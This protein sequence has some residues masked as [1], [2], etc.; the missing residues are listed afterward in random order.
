MILFN[1]VYLQSSTKLDSHYLNSFNLELNITNQQ[2]KHSSVV[3]LFSLFETNY[4]YVENVIQE[5][6]KQQDYSKT[7]FI[8]Y[9]AG[10]QIV[11]Y[12]N[13]KF[14]AQQRKLV[15]QQKINI[16][17][18][19]VNF[20]GFD[21]IQI[22]N[23]FIVKVDQNATDQEIMNTLLELSDAEYFCNW[24]STAFH[25]SSRVSLQMK[26][27]E[28]NNANVSVLKQV[29]TY[30][31]LD[32]SITMNE[33]LE[34]QLE[35]ILFKRECL[36]NINKYSSF[37]DLTLQIAQ[38]NTVSQVNAVT[39]YLDLS[40][41]YQK[42][43]MILDDSSAKY[44]LNLARP[45]QRFDAVISLGAWCQVNSM[46]DMRGLQIV[47]S[48]FAGFAFFKWD[49]LVDVLE[50][51]FSHYWEEKNVHLGRASNWYSY[52]YKD[53]RLVRHAYDSRYNMFSPHHFDLCD[54]SP[55]NS[56]LLYKEFSQKL[57]HKIQ[58]FNL[59]A[60]QSR[61]V[62]LLKIMDKHFE[63][64]NVTNEQIARLIL[65]LQKYSSD[66]ELRI[67]VPIWAKHALEKIL[68]KYSY[69]F[70]KIYV[71]TVQW[72]DDPYHKD[73]EEMVG[74]IVLARGSE[75]VDGLGSLMDWAWI[76]R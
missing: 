37:S 14:L 72:N 75:M 56:Y 53:T 1:F 54:C 11:D 33:D 25:D 21:V 71:W 46:L 34:Q 74:D 45:K 40:D 66:F 31:Y 10:L 65:S 27:M 15:L 76:N 48:P 57:Q 38:Q 50:S 69:D 62:F 20:Y 44:L 5:F 18:Q 70:I 4:Q 12:F 49:R 3:A 29:P 47:H 55:A 19:Y 39:A 73:W 26:Q 63:S 23:L 9:K 2:N 36:E 61:P 64:T 6:I 22:E 67:S 51:N 58:I 16:D 52:K 28:L 7:L 17:D 60:K 68:R 59:Q 8:I 43:K 41:K 24:S 30:H 32:S 13:Y 35:T 42:S